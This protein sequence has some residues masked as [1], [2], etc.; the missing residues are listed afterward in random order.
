MITSITSLPYRPT[1]DRVKEIGSHISGKEGTILF[2]FLST[3]LLMSSSSLALGADTTYNYFHLRTYEGSTPLTEDNGTKLDQWQWYSDP[4]GS[5]YTAPVR[6]NR[7]FLDNSVTVDHNDASNCTDAID[8]V[9]FNI[10]EDIFTGQTNTYSNKDPFPAVV[11]EGCNNESSG[12]VVSEIFEIAYSDKFR[13]GEWVIYTTTYEVYNGSDYETV[14]TWDVEIVADDWNNED[15]LSYTAEAPS[16]I[17]EDTLSFSANASTVP[18]T[19]I[20]QSPPDGSN[21]SVIDFP[22]DFEVEVLDSV[23]HRTC[24]YEPSGEVDDE[25]CIVE[26]SRTNQLFAWLTGE[27][28]QCEARDDYPSYNISEGD[29]LEGIYCD[30]ETKMEYDNNLSLWATLPDSRRKNLGTK[31]DV[32]EE[33]YTFQLRADGFREEFDNGSYPFGDWSTEFVYYDKQLEGNVTSEVRNITIEEPPL[34]ENLTE[35]IGQIDSNFTK[36]WNDLDENTNEKAQFMTS[37]IFIL[38]FGVVGGIYASYKGALGGAF[39]IS[40]MFLLLGWLPSWFSVALLVMAGL[41]AVKVIFGV[42]GENE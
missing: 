14:D 21:F 35:S 23:K 19:L 33:V 30:S 28:I 27:S 20:Y 3:F 5:F 7:T 24:Y 4:S 1:G 15:T 26:A 9:R 36:S 17:S 32:G 2:V 42:F 18:A 11:G 34:D 13:A 40:L 29:T 41:F 16:W 12:Y 25:Y 37:L 39:T 10:T 31:E 8:K 22:Y 38:I 6:W